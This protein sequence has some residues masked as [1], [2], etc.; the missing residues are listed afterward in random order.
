MNAAVSGQVWRCQSSTSW[1]GLMLPPLQMT[2]TFRS[3][4]RAGA[5]STAASAAAPAGSTRFLVF[6][7]IA[8][9]AARSASSDTTTKS[10]SSRHKIRCGKSNAV[11]VASPSASVLFCAVTRARACH[12]RCAAG[13]ASAWTPMTSIDGRTAFAT[14]QVPASDDDLRAKRA[15]GRH[16][17]RVGP[18]RNADDCADPEQVRRV[19]HRL[20]VVASGRGDDTL[21]PLIGA[22][23]AD[24]V[25]ATADLECPDR[26]MI[27][28]L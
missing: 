12:E 16:L 21:A 27:L 26:L 24:Q 15:H 5:S 25:H 1:A 10:S 13:A 22:E 23:L 6:S 4:N 14:V 11:L 2:A 18:L 17:H 19:R 3:A 8:L 7:I 9:V 20:T 28:V